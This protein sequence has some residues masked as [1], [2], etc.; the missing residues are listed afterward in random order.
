MSET[1]TLRPVTVTDVTLELLRTMAALCTREADLLVRLGSAA[2][3]A[4]ALSQEETH[5]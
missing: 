4:R 3:A 2:Y 1:T 5:G